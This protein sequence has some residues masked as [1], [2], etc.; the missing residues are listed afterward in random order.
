M[1]VIRLSQMATVLAA[2]ATAGLLAWASIGTGAGLKDPAPA[3]I[4]IAQ[5][6]PS[7]P[8]G[9]PEDD[10]ENRISVRGRVIA[11][12]GKPVRD[13]TIHVGYQERPLRPGEPVA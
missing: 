11:P 3:A 7:R 8:V 9:G 10:E 13:A 12:D 6:A 2:A 5:R 1:L 4:T